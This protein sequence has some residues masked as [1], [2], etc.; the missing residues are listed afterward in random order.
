MRPKG[1]H[2]LQ[3]TGALTVIEV[4]VVVVVMALLAGLVMPWLQKSSAKANRLW[5]TNNLKG[6][7]LSYRIFATDHTNR[8]PWQISSNGGGTRQFASDVSNVWRH[9]AAISNELSSPQTAFCPS[10]IARREARDFSKFNSNQNLSYFIG[11]GASFDSPQSILSGDRNLMLDGSSLEGQILTLSRN[12]NVS[13]DRRIHKTEGNVLLGD[14]SVQ[15]LT[16]AR[17]RETIRDAGKVST[18]TLMVP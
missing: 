13:F 12:A 5:C 3:K 6:I 9:V 11:L 10:D 15:M 17:L 14:G 18:N 4:L 7:G 2:A 8:F 1:K 16:S